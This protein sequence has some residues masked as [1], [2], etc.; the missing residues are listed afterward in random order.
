MTVRPS[1]RFVSVWVFLCLQRTVSF[2]T[3]PSKCATVLLHWND[4]VVYNRR[5]S[6]KKNS[7]ITLHLTNVLQRIYGGE[8]DD[9]TKYKPSFTGALCSRIVALLPL[10]CT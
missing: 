3:F 5:N 1:V 10:A 4:S 8:N 9:G 2:L 7:S 6:T